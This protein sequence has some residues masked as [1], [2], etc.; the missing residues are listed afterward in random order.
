MSLIM[1]MWVNVLL[2]SFDWTGT[3]DEQRLSSWLG[4]EWFCDVSEVWLAAKLIVLNT[5]KSSKDV[6]ASIVVGELR[7][8]TEDGDDPGSD[9]ICV[10]RLLGCDILRLITFPESSLSDISAEYWDG[11]GRWGECKTSSL[12]FS[13]GI[14]SNDVLRIEWRRHDFCRRF[15]G[16]SEKIKSDVT[17][18]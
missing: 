9:A 4:S 6:L 5:W 2:R 17:K 12:R 18:V 13:M 3:S 16:F 7:F 14:S 11:E 8:A 15:K 1:S 10:A